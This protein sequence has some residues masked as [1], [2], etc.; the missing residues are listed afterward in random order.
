[1]INP[2][3]VPERYFP[4]EDELDQFMQV[5]AAD[6]GDIPSH[7]VDQLSAA[8]RE[9]TN[10]LIAAAP[11]M[12]ATGQ[13]RWAFADQSGNPDP[14]QIRD[15]TRQVIVAMG[16]GVK[17]LCAHTNLIRPWLLICD[18]PVIACI[19][20]IASR[21][22]DLGAVD[23]D[24]GHFWNYQCDRCGARTELLSKSTVSGFGHLTIVGH[25]CRSCAD[26]D[27]QRVEQLADTVALVPPIR[28]KRTPAP[29]ARGRRRRK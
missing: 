6:A 24:L 9:H 10:W 19:K 12:V 2:A 14:D 3:E 5:G 16:A 13:A 7:V 8:S 15:V 21:K 25:I 28:R 17:H 29:G 26:Q 20:C 27:R 4:T 1:V 22:V 11:H 18:P 23:R